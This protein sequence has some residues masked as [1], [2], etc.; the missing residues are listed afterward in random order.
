[1]RTTVQIASLDGLLPNTKK[2]HSHIVVYS[3]LTG[4][5]SLLVIYCLCLTCSPATFVG[6]LQYFAK[7]YQL[8]E[9]LKVQA[10]FSRYNTSNELNSQSWCL[11]LCRANYSV[12]DARFRCNEYDQGEK[13]HN[14]DSLTRGLR[15][16]S[17][18]NDRSRLGYTWLLVTLGDDAGVPLV[19]LGVSDWI[20]QGNS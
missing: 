15:Q 6:L 1:M 3:V 8:R 18:R 14:R 17:H 12:G 19:L 10:C 4:P 16:V 9:G 20:L 7:Y 5:L 13:G 2:R 11:F